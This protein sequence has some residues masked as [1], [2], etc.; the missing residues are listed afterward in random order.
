MDDTFSANRR[1]DYEAIKADIAALKNQIGDLA[2]HFGGAAGEEARRRG[3]RALYMAGEPVRD[4]PLVSV[5]TALAIGYI[6]GRF[7]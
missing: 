3:K 1:D 2:G 5:M 7:S 6:A 4:W